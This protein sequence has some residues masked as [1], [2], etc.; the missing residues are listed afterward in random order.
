M[1]ELIVSATA[2]VTVQCTLA[3]YTYNN[4]GCI[5]LT[6]QL[7]FQKLSEQISYT[8]LTHVEL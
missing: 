5:A 2:T 1:N 3:L 6:C 8:A 7:Y 4:I